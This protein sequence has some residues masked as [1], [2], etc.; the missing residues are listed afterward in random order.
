MK[1][2]VIYKRH[3]AIKILLLIGLGFISAT[4]CAQI[5]PTDSIPGDPGAIIVYTV[6]NMSFGAFSIGS[7]GGTV[8]ISTSGSRSVSGDVVAL[9]LGTPYFQAIFDIDAPQGAIVSILNGSDVTLN[10]SNG[11]SMSMHIGNSDPPSPFVITVPQPVRTQVSI[12]GTLTAG[13]PGANPP[14][15]YNGTFYITF[16]LE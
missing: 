1:A 13:S 14:G 3:W 15:T 10:G 16:N 2:I 6:Q 9:N 5:D 12:G 11:G 7:A 4:A 8:I